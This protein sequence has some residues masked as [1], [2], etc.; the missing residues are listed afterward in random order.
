MDDILAT[1]KPASL[2]LFRLSDAVVTSLSTAAI[3]TWTDLGIRSWSDAPVGNTTP[4]AGSISV[5]SATGIAGP[6]S[7]MFTARDSPSGV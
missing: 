7:V 5:S 3:D 1:L 2:V 6:E 4:I